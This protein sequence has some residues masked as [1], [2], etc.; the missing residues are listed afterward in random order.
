MLCITGVRMMPENG[1]QRMVASV[2]GIGGLPS[3]ISPLP[4]IS[5]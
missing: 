4:G 5:Q 1:G 2:W 3:S